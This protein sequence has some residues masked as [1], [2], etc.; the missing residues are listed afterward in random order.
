MLNEELISVIVPCYNIEEYV[1]RCIKSIIHQTY[2]NLEI[3]AIDDGSK[4]NTG[5]ILDRIAA[6]ESRMI[7]F[8]FQ[9]EGLSC[10]RNHGLEN[11]NGMFI[12][13]IDGD[14]FIDTDMIRK[15]YNMAIRHDLDLVASNYVLYY[16]KEK[17]VVGNTT[18][19]TCANETS[20]DF[21]NRLFEPSKCFCSACAKLYKR[22]LFEGVEYPRDVFFG[23]DMLVAPILF[24]KAKRLGYTEEPLYFYN[25]QGTSLVRSKFNINKLYMVKA[26]KNWCDF[27]ENKYP[28]LLNKATDNYYATMINMCT[29]LSA[30]KKF[31]EYFNEY[32]KT[33]QKALKYINTSELRRNDKIKANMI[34]RMSPKV[35]HVIHSIVRNK[36]A[37]RC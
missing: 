10:A 21:I 14:D 4:D 37:R 6:V 24:D 26:A 31:Y 11:A 30:E 22:E 29:Y 28:K 17:Q 18:D 12:M 1:E 35:Y 7:V 13:C 3:I 34:S 33:L 25:Q 20:E 2:K 9:N 8:H 15:L 16:S 5:E 19:K 27:C 32:K 36:Q 23:E